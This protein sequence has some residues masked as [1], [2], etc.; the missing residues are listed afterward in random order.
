MRVRR[1]RF[2]ILASATPV[3]AVAVLSLAAGRS[4]ALQ[5]VTP[6]PATC[7]AYPDPN[8]V[9]C[10]S[11]GRPRPGHTFTGVYA[12]FRHP[13]QVPVTRVSCDAKIGG[14]IVRVNGGIGFAGGTHLQ[15]ILHRYYTPPDASGQQY[16]VRATCGWDIPRSDRRKLLSLLHPLKDI[17]CDVDCEPWGFHVDYSNGMREENQTTWRV[18]R[19]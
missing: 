6:N 18:A 5:T 10:V 3:I 16:L 9:I 7:D 15:P 11:K 19:R 2:L 8:S 17:P 12:W 13:R 4:A 14:K 1:W